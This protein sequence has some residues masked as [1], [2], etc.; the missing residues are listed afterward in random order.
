MTSRAAPTPS[1]PSC[2]RKAR[3][4][5][6]GLGTLT[7]CVVLLTTLG[8]AAAWAARQLASAQR[9][10]ANDL[11]GA[12]AAEAAE[13]GLAWTLAMLNTGRVDDHC[14]PALR[15]AA[16]DVAPDT[17][18]SDASGTSPPSATTANA[19]PPP[20]AAASDFRERFLSIGS[21]GHYRAASSV[22]D[23][24]NTGSLRWVCRCGA[25][26]ASASG[27]APA[28]QP[29]FSIRFGNGAAAGMLLLVA[30]G[31]SDVAIDCD[32]LRDGPRGVAEVSQQIALLSALRH[33]PSTP[34]LEGVDAFTRVFGMPPARYRSQPAV[35]RLRCGPDCGPAISQ[36]LAR[37]R[38]LLW[39]DGDARLSDLPSVATDGRPLVLIATGRLD[40]STAAS[41][42]GLLYARDGVRWHPPAGLAASIRG[43]VVTDGVIDRGSNV[44]LVHDA[45]A[46][47]QISRRM[48]SFLPVPGGWT[49]TR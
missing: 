25:T 5:L 4:R 41:L 44:A 24:V 33:P 13:A 3:H 42:R 29:F 26:A 27:P 47:Q 23:C 40:L 11:R 14:R 9:V 31:C 17:G 49:P 32:D 43:A 2:F 20:G 6:R 19:S 8:L 34:T 39:V 15:D 38:R 48:G 28:A 1:R 22:A 30:K 46:L 12:A 37:G 21:D 18:G 35:T 36:A 16:S 7:L 45:A 10:A